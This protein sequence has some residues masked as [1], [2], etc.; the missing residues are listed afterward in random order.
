MRFPDVYDYAA[1]KADWIAM[2]LAT[3]R[4][5]TQPRIEQAARKD[6]PT[7]GVQDRIGYVRSKLPDDWN[8]CVV[9]NSDRI[10]LGLVEFSDQLEAEKIVEEI[11][12]P[13]PLTFRPGRPVR[14]IC[15][16]LKSK[17]VRVALVTTSVGQFVGVLRRDELCESG[18]FS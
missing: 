6:A 18:A 9:L 12:H 5:D 8:I 2:G 15:E 13:A 3:E 11:M 7:C 17:N 14:E 4:R 1:G 16:Y 10:V